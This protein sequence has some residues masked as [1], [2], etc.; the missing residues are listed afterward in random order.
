MDGL[1]AFTPGLR[2][3]CASRRP[4]GSRLCERQGRKLWMSA[5]EDLYAT[6]GVGEGADASYKQIRNAYLKLARDLHPDS[7][8]GGVQ[9]VQ[10]TEK[11]DA[12]TKA[13]SVL[14]DETLRKVYDKLGFEGL[15]AHEALMAQK[16]KKFI[17]EGMDPLELEVQMSDEAFIAGVFESG[18]DLGDKFEYDPDLHEDYCPRSKEEAVYNLKN[19]EVI[20]ARYFAAW[21]VRRF[22]VFEAEQ[23]L[24]ESLLSTNMRTEEMYKLRKRTVMALGKVAQ[25]RP[26]K[27]ATMRALGE[28]IQEED[29][30]LRE[31]ALHSLGLIAERN[32]GPEGIPQYILDV[33]KDKV[34]KSALRLQKIDEGQASQTDIFDFDHLEPEVA[35]KLKAIIRARKETLMSDVDGYKYGDNKS[36]PLPTLILTAN[37]L[38]LFELIEEVRACLDHPKSLVRAASN[39]FMYSCTGDEKY[40]ETLFATMREGT[41]TISSDVYIALRCGDM[42][43]AAIGLLLVSNFIPPSIKVCAF[44]RIY[45]QTQARGISPELK[46]ELFSALDAVIT[47]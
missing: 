45:N 3:G 23:P 38:K 5:R 42:G 6:L 37:N 1:L 4:H 43:G 21:W 25:V 13:Y 20:A 46:T 8:E 18:S 9:T 47:K 26:V 15:E 17:F 32:R 19:H 12:I 16:A 10:E 34:V 27:E 22:N 11:F 35:E 29:F 14:T 30:F 39:L 28:C 24:V 7:V 41:G 31:N 36:E 2:T 40:V 44:E 33:V